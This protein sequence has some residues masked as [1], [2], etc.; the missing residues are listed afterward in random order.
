MPDVIALGFEK[1]LP[2]KFL[3]MRRDADADVSLEQIYL[4]I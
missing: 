1:H 4:G 2:E 3:T